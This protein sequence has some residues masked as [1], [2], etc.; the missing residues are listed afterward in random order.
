MKAPAQ[1]LFT[2]GT[3]AA[4]PALTGRERE[5]AVLRQC[6]ADL[7]DGR[8]PPHDV[9]LMGP[10]GNGKTVLLNWFEGAC[11]EAGRI[12]IARLSPSRIRTGEALV[13]ASLPPSAFR[14]LLPRKLGVAGVGQAEWGA[15]GPSVQNLTARLTARCRKKPVVVL[16][17]EAHTL[18]R[19]VGQLL[20]NVSQEVRANAPLLLV[21]A[22]TP[23]LPAHLGTMNASFWGRLDEGRL[24]IGLLSD[25]AARAAL[26]E[27]LTTHG[28]SIDAGTLDAVVEDSQRYPYFIQV[29]G[30]ALWQQ[31]LTTGA[32]RLTGAHADAV[33]PDVAARVADYYQDRY[34]ELESRGLLPAAVATAR[35]FQAAATA[36][37]HAIDAALAA[38]GADADGR[39]AAR[40]ELNRLGYVWTPPGQL[41]PIVWVTGIPSL[42][43]H[44]AQRYPV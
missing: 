38:T 7:L 39:L 40:E 42:M 12:T 30:R 41:P 26:V 25:A 23:G 2:P 36:S 32:A 16:I 24:G 15:N 34:R 37:D 43:T 21:L 17:D 9:A 28:V 3:G 33:L 31:H 20:L 29:W 8:A 44:V 18:D 13:D 27:P 1:R 5:Q 35:L 4:P 6:L 22:G 14:K 19:D 11:R 10:R